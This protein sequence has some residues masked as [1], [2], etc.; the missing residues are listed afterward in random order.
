MIQQDNDRILYVRWIKNFHPKTQN[1][2]GCRRKNQDTILFKA[3]YYIYRAVVNIRTVIFLLYARSC[4]NKGVTRPENLFINIAP[5][6]IY[7]QRL[8]ILKG[9]LHPDGL[10]GPVA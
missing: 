8:K 10:Y 2:C 4:M 7:E 9:E 3:F 5:D 6:I 1:I